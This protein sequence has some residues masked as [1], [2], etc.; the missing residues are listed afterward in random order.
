[1][2]NKGHSLIACGIVFFLSVFLYFMLVDDLLQF[3]MAIL[4]LSTL[5]LSE[6]TAFGCLLLLPDAYRSITLSAVYGVQAIF[7]A[8]I[9]SLFVTVFIFSYAG[10]LVA[11]ILSFAL[12]ALI[13]L[14]ILHNLS[15]AATKDQAFR[16]A[17]SSALAIRATVQRMICSKEGAPYQQV[18]HQLDEDLRFMDDSQID[19][20]DVEIQSRINILSSQLATPGFDVNAS[21]TDIRNLI[22]QRDFVVKHNKSYR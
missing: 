9:G 19:T 10:Y 1:M 2:K 14:F 12:A 6:L 3:P 4:T 7:T 11:Y 5:L 15:E 22:Q 18:L 20:M 13:S 8:I 17:K 16:R 21:V